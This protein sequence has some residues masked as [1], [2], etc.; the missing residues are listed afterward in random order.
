[1]RLPWMSMRIRQLRHEDIPRAM[2]LSSQA[3]W[4]QAPSDWRRLIDLTPNGCFAGWVDEDL[5]ATST[6]VTYR[7][8]SGDYKSEYRAGWIGMVLVEESYRRQGYGM[9]I[10]EHA[11]K[12]A[13]EWNI[14][15]IGLDATSAGRPI[16]EENGFVAVGGIQRWQGVLNASQLQ[17]QKRRVNRDP[18]LR[19]VL[20]LD[21]LSCEINRAGLLS[22]LANEDGVQII[23]IS[24][25]NTDE[26]LGYA[27]VRPGRVH[28]HLGPLLAS[29]LD[30]LRTILG[31]VE[32][33]F[34]TPHVIM[35]VHG[36]DVYPTLRQANLTNHRNLTRMTHRK[37]YRMFMAEEI[38]GAAGFELG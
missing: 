3:G 22:Q 4:N 36:R 7:D 35:D 17:S 21:R 34:V 24:D 30:T 26:D 19:K 9:R 27:F 31:A 1:M 38:V 14:P 18:N 11:L 6:L 16:Y 37:K 20:R 28:R 25:S 23:L 8:A 33:L 10:F 2:S 12:K 29:D 15:E 13:L 5:I 32:E